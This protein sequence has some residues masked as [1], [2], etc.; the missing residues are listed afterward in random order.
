MASSLALQTS[1]V[2]VH[3]AVVVPVVVAGA[4]TPA[5]AAAAVEEIEAA[6]IVVFEV[7]VGAFGKHIGG[8]NE[9]RGGAAEDFLDKG[10][11]WHG[12]SGSSEGETRPLVT[13]KKCIELDCN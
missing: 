9:G 8:G 2:V 1:A 4:F 6:F 3:C 11:L 5:N 12:E 7:V 13:L 10:G